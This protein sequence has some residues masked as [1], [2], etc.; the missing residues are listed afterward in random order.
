MTVNGIN[1][2]VKSHS[3]VFHW[4]TSEKSTAHDRRYRSLVNA[5]VIK[6]PLSAS[7]GLLARLD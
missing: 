7:M 5:S 2:T 3:Q 6:V 4:S 1:S